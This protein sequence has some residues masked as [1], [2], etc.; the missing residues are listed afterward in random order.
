[1]PTAFDGEPA[2]QRPDI[3]F[4]HGTPSRRGHDPPHS[5]LQRPPTLQVRDQHPPNHDPA[6]VAL[7]DDLTRRHKILNGV[8]NEHRR[9]A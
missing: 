2:G 6:A 3:E 7:L 9:A 5:P 1:M 4:W 8:V